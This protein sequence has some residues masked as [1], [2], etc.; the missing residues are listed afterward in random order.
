[1]ETLSSVSLNERNA[2]P[3]WASPEFFISHKRAS[4]CS[5]WST[6]R[7]FTRVSWDHCGGWA[8]N[9]AFLH[10][11]RERKKIPGEDVSKTFAFRLTTFPVW[12]RHA[13]LCG[14]VKM[15]L[16]YNLT[17]FPSWRAWRYLALVLTKTSPG[18]GTCAD[19]SPI[20]HPFEGWG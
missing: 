10:Q 1:M 13:W 14:W 16:G 2:F 18:F 5:S 12:P 11:L 8:Q 20:V 19:Q 6:F 7:P 15:R 3:F 4:H 17:A 9:G